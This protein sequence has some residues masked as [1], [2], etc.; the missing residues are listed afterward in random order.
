MPGDGMHLQAGTQH[1]PPARDH[2]VHA[3]VADHHP[4]HPVRGTRALEVGFRAA[5]PPVCSST[6]YSSTTL[7]PKPSAMSRSPG[8]DMSEDRGTRLGIRR[9][10]V[11]CQRRLLSASR[12]PAMRNLQ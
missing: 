10:A 6:S 5:E 4:V 1:A 8:G 11:R 3:R 7:P 2:V 12:W 9:S